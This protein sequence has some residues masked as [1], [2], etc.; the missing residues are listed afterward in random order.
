MVKLSIFFNHHHHTFAFLQGFV[1]GLADAREVFSIGDDTVDDDFD[2]VDLVSIHLHFRRDLHDLSVNPYFGI[3]GFTYLLEQL[4]VM[5][6]PAFDYGCQ[7][8]ELLSL[9]IIQ[10]RIEDLIFRLPDHLIAAEIGECFSGARVQ[11]THKI[12]DLRHRSYS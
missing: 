9:E 5:T 11:E 12:V 7:Q 1:N 4:A 3:S 6:F 2:V 8:Y 10:D